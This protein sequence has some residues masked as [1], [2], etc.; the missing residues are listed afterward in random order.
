MICFEHWVTVGF[1][2][3][4]QQA[5]RRDSKHDYFNLGTPD[6]VKMA[7]EPK[8]GLSFVYTGSKTG[9]T[10]PNRYVLIE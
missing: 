9:T 8:L 1:L 5:C 7:Y 6:K 4:S 3:I 2:I 10:T